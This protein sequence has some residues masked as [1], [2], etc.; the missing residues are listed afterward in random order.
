MNCSSYHVQL[1][2]E[3]AEATMADSARIVV[4][5]RI[6]TR[7]LRIYSASSQHIPTTPI[8]RA[9]NLLMPMSRVMWRTEMH[10]CTTHR[11]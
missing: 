5:M 3:A 8:P 10:T 6:P 2:A 9:R 4:S 11:M 1:S 7:T